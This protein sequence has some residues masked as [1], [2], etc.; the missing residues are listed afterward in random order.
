MRQTYQKINASDLYYLPSS[1]THP[2]DTYF[3]FSFADYYNPLRMNFGVLR[4]LNDDQISAHSGFDRHPHQDM[5]IVTYV[6]SGQLTHWDNLTNKQQTIGRG[7]VQ[8]ISAGSGIFHSELNEQDERCRLLQIWITPPQKGGAVRYD[9][10]QFSLQDREN[11]LLQIVG[12]PDNKDNVLLYVNSDVNLYVSELTQAQAVVQ[13]NLLPERQAY[14][15]CIEGSVHIDGYPALNEKE[16]LELSA[17]GVLNFSVNGKH[18]H[19]I[20]IEMPK[21]A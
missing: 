4:V 17:D 12:N 8:A 7:H 16:S 3:H 18:A 6:I 15:N 19:F 13:F 2:A 1:D 21:T 14:I 5:Q 11:K 9:Q 20:I 10:Q